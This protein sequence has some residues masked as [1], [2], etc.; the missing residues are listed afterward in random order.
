MSARKEII[1]VCAYF[2]E[3]LVK[4]F[5]ELE[6]TIQKQSGLLSIFKKINYLDRANAFNGLLE[7]AIEAKNSLPL[8]NDTKEDYEIYSLATKL[9]ECLAIYINMIESQVNLNIH[10]NQKANGEKYSWNE[11]TKCLKLFEMQRNAL[12]NELPK[13][14]SLYAVI[15]KNSD[16]NESMGSKEK[17]NERDLAEIVISQYLNQLECDFDNILD[18]FIKFGF[19]ENDLQDENWMKYDI[20]LCGLT[21]DGMAL[22]N[23][24]DTSQAN[25]IF[26][27]ISVDKFM[28][29]DNEHQRSYSINRVSEYRSIWD[30][31]IENSEPP[32]DFVFSKL[33]EDLLGE[34]IQK[35]NI[36]PLHMIQIISLVTPIFAGKWKAALEHYEPIQ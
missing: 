18:S 23:L 22:F 2:F 26:N 32:F 13:L 19:D 36:G 34:N 16:N 12:E 20:F 28:S 6:T 17:I 5:L 1:A 3:V 29:L 33:F 10:L 25:R 30:Y 4:K 8:D 14:N 35:Y 21:I 9:T 15:L 27:Y 31:C 7:R 24:I 11:Y